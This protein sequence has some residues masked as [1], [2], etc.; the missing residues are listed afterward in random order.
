MSVKYVKIILSIILEVN[1]NKITKKRQQLVDCNIIDD[2]PFSWSTLFAIT[3]CHIL[4]LTAIRIEWSIKVMFYDLRY[5]LQQLLYYHFIMIS[6]YNNNRTTRR[7]ILQYAIEVRM[8][9][10]TIDK[11][12]YWRKKLIQ[13]FVKSF[14]KVVIVKISC[15][16]E[17]ALKDFNK[18][19]SVYKEF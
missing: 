4:H 1:R 7:R 9:T 5:K 14:H 6:S 8:S 19:L 13:S 3:A 15:I 17:S 16:I 18:P 10:L 2:E 11:K 12:S